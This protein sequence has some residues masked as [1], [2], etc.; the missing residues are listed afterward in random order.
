MFG[1]GFLSDCLDEPW[2]DPNKPDLLEYA[3]SSEDN[4]GKPS[5]PY[6]T[7]KKFSVPVGYTIKSAVVDSGCTTSNFSHSDGFVTGYFCFY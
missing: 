5:L 3:F 4:D 6:S 2:L 7:L 1:E